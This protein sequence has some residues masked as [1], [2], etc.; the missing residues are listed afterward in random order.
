[1]TAHAQQLA[2]IA[3]PLWIRHSI[4]EVPREWDSLHEITSS[5]DTRTRLMVWF[6]FVRDD[7]A[8]R[9]EARLDVLTG[10][11]VLTLEE[12]GGCQ[13]IERFRHAA[14]LRRR[15]MQEEVRLEAECWR[16]AGRPIVIVGPDSHT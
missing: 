15:L 1:M 6:Y 9:L 5:R 16:R 12:P 3:V 14:T 2:N 8:L 4:A 13:R 11:Y 7:K 10:D